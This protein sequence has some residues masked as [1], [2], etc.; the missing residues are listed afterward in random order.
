LYTGDRAYR[1][2]A[3]LVKKPEQDAE[4]GGG[5]GEKGKEERAGEVNGEEK[6][7]GKGDREVSKEDGGKSLGVYVNEDKESGSVGGGMNIVED[8]FFGEEIAEGI[9]KL[10][11]YIH[12]YM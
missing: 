11:S 5:G 10:M 12:L 7:T 3:L 6:G 9:Q 4:G 8:R 1:L 2:A